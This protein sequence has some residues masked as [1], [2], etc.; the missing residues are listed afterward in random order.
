MLYECHVM[1][2]I[3]FVLHSVLNIKEPMQSWQ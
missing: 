1:F 3:T 2:T